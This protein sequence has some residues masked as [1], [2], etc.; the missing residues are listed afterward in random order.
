[1]AARKC[2]GHRAPVRPQSE[3]ATQGKKS[4]SADSDPESA[5]RLAASK[6]GSR[7]MHVYQAQSGVSADDQ[8]L[9]PPARASRA[10]T[11]GRRTATPLSVGPAGTR[12]NAAWAWK[13][14]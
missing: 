12:G 8:R 5:Y 7:R 14:V 9:C 2:D 6:I 3:R 11:A 4:M 1:M 10:S 13:R